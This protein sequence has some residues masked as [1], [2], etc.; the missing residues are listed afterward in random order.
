MHSFGLTWE[1]IKSFPIIFLDGDITLEAKQLLEDTYKEIINQL[2]AKILIFDFSKTD[3]INS[4]GISYFLNILQRHKER[5]GEFIFTSLSD[6]IKK[7]M[8]IVGLTD[9]VKVFSTT[10]TAIKYLDK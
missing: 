2:D 5:G 9:Y 7:V 3:Y 4:T 1:V 10:E 6:H 8:N